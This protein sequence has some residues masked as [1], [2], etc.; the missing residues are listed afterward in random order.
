M[1][2]NITV[3]SFQR[4]LVCIVIVTAFTYQIGFGPTIGGIT[5]FPFRLV[6]MGCLGLMA[7]EILMNN[8]FL[9]LSHIH[10]KPY[11]LFIFLWAVYSLL[12]IIWA[13]DQIA[14]IKYNYVILHGFLFLFFIVYYMSDL[15]SL[16]RIYW[17]LLIIYIALLLVAYWEITTGEHL[18]L[19]HYHSKFTQ[20]KIPIPTTV[21]FNENDYATFLSLTL[22]LVIVWIRYMSGFIAR[23]AGFLFLIL[24]IIVLLMTSSRACYLA[25]ALSVGFWYLFLIR[26]NKKTIILS[27][28]C[29]L[30]IAYILSGRLLDHLLTQV[31][32]LAALVSNKVQDIGGADIR[33]NLY[34]NALYFSGLSFP[35]GVGAGNSEYYFIN[36]QVY[37]IYSLNSIHNWWLEILVNY[38]VPVFIGYVF[39]YFNVIYN[40]WLIHKRLQERYEKMICESLLMGWVGFSLSSISPSS[41]AGFPPQWLYLGFILAFINYYAGCSNR[42]SCQVLLKAGDF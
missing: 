23:F 20:W 12:S 19:S 8:F 40:L 26:H 1:N 25:L 39:L 29:F 15:G 34:L 10:V 42:S 33:L 14:A 30:V 17:L 36:Y 7:I 32:S 31:L 35:I 4:F 2:I 24:G 9:D 22:P 11:L 27:A 41:L 6:L 38:G 3:A 13:A 21:Y 18:F 28:C 5:W 37:P 16:K